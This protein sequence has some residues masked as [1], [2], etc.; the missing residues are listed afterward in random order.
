MALIALI[1]RESAAAV[2]ERR[3]LQQQGGGFDL[4]GFLLVATFLGALEVMLDRG[5]EDDWFGVDLHRH[6]RGR[7]RAWPSCS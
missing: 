6:G 3:R 4:V 5:L 2:A 1:L 7:L